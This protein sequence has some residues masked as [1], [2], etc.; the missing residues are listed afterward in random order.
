VPGSLVGTGFSCVRAHGYAHPVTSRG[1]APSTGPEGNPWFAVI[2]SFPVAMA[3]ATGTEAPSTAIAQLGQLG[4]G[5]RR[6]F[7]RG[8]LALTFLIVAGLTIALAGLAVRLHVGIP[9]ANSTQI[10]DIAHA[11]AGHSALYALF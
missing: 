11:A 3:L 2:V 6:R 4:P 9:A 5:D 1:H 8:T 10:A 7:A